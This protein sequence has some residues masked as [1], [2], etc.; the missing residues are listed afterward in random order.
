MHAAATAALQM[1]IRLAQLSGT[2]Q[3]HFISVMGNA[4][5]N[6]F[7][8]AR[9]PDGF[10]R[11]REGDMRQLSTYINAKCVLRPVWFCSICLR[12][13]GSFWVYLFMLSKYKRHNDMGKLPSMI[14]VQHF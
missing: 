10:Q 9:L 7:W 13:L 1:I 14:F 4:R 2:A 11:P 5:A 3:V 8:E 12:H 6:V